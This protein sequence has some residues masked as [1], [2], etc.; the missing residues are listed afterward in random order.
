MDKASLMHKVITGTASKEEKAE[1]D[2]WLAADEANR[3]DYYDM[4]I[5]YSDPVHLAGDTDPSPDTA[6]PRL[7]AAMARINR[8]KKFRKWLGKFTLAAGL[9]LVVLLAYDARSVSGRR[10]VAPDRLARSTHFAGA[11]IDEVL[12]VIEESGRVKVSLENAGI[13]ACRFTGSFSRGTSYA[14]VLEVI[15]AAT[16]LKVS[17]STDNTLLLSGDGCVR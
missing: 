6:W 14:V 11:S 8:K 15:A 3:E 10:D 5:L 16:D 2:D 7:E 12:R 13:A 17:V 9:S 4:I 1:L